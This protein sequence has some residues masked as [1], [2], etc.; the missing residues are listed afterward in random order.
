MRGCLILL[1]R[2]LG[3]YF[4]S[5]TG[6]VVISAVVFLIGLGYIGLIEAVNNEP[7]TKSVVEM[8]FESHYFWLVLLLVSP[9]ITMRTF[10]REKST[11]TFET[12]MTSPT[13]EIEVVAAKFL[14]AL[15]F[16]II[17]W[18]PLIICMAVIQEYMPTDLSS[19]F[20]RTLSVFAGVVLVGFLYMAM[21]CFAS[22]LSRS[23]TSAAIVGYAF[24]IG[25]FILSF[26]SYAIN[27]QLGLISTV[28]GYINMIEHIRDFA[29]GVI[30]T[31]PIVF[32]LT[33][34]FLFLN[35]T[36]RVIESRRW[37]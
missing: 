16:Y 28:L 1:R 18:S 31:R 21:G 6:Y 11:G 15:I 36:L 20:G 9:L 26:L 4:V 5:W 13:T 22:A 8:F 37:K 25:L 23:Q 14:A 12:L 33:T 17:M 30:D 29:R 19:D 10:A 3:S 7:I 24:G 27:P 2:E 35:L 32:Y 34:S